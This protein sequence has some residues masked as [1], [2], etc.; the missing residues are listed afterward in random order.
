[1]PTTLSLSKVLKSQAGWYRG[2]FH[3]HTHFSDGFQSPPDLVEVAR[4]EGL[5]FFAITDHNTIGAYTEFGEVTD[6]VIIPGLEVTLEIGHYNVF[7]IEGGLDWLPDVCVWPAPVPYQAGRYKT[8]S[9][10]MRRTAGQGLLNSINHPLLPPWDWLDAE[11]DLRYVHCLEI[12]NDPSWPDNVRGNPRAV[13]LWTQW[14]NQGYRITAIG[15]SDYHR[16][17]PKPGENKPAERLG[18]PSTFVYAEELS[19][20]AILAGIRERRAYVSMGPLV[21]FQAISEGD[22]H[23]IGADLGNLA[24]DIQFRGTVSHKTPVR[25]QVLKNGDVVT[26]EDFKAGS[27]ELSYEDASTG[28]EPAWYRLD[29]LDHRGHIL[30]VTNPIFAGPQ[31]K[32]SVRTYGDFVEVQPEGETKP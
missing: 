19:G 13:A 14:L 25:V 2:D 22:V 20:A 17:Y 12:W 32:P 6:I 9:E 10:L 30:A 28:G 7:G 26:T 5:D 8:P 23:D 15:G 29:V 24:G 21:T 27:G 1:M 31:K 3:A 18:L 4:V 16:P 11:T